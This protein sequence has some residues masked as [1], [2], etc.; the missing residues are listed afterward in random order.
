MNEKSFNA[1][2][3]LMKW[4]G[5]SKEGGN[6]FA[7]AD[8]DRNFE[9]ACWDVITS[10]LPREIYRAAVENRDLK[11]LLDSA[12]LIP[13]SD[14]DGSESSPLEEFLWYW[15][16]SILSSIHQD[17]GD[18]SAVRKHFDLF[19]ELS[20]DFEEVRAE[21]TRVRKKNTVPEPTDRQVSKMIEDAHAPP[22]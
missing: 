22:F 5:R 1:N 7:V 20:R 15:Q 10:D 16:N 17:M 13:R 12:E 19:A 3:I 6:F 2:K 11:V 8:I 4:V 21:R 14:F 18:I 9:S